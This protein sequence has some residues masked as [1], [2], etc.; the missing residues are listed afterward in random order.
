VRL[1]RLLTASEGQASRERPTLIRLF[2]ELRE[3]SIWQFGY[4]SSRTMLEAERD[5]RGATLREFQP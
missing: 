1:D 2:E 5:F 3:A 4:R